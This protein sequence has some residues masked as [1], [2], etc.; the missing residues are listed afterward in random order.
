[1]KFNPLC[2]IVTLTGAYLLFRLR[3]FFILHPFRCLK[4]TCASLKKRQTARS[5]VLALAGT[6]GVGNVFGVAVGISVGGAGSL[7]WM[8]VSSL[9]ASVIKYSEVLLSQASMDKRGSESHG[10]IHNALL[11]LGKFGGVLAVVY[12]SSTLLLSF[13]MG[14]ALQSSTLVS[15]VGQIFDTPPL[16]TSVILSFFVLLAVVGGAAIIERVTEIVIPVTTIIYII[17]CS[18]VIFLCYE[19]VPSALSEVWRSAF[20][21]ES[22]FGGAL[23][24]LLSRSL[25]EG[26][27]RG[28]LSNEAGAGTS[29]MA[30][31]R[32]ASL[33]PA[34]S[35]LMGIVEVFFDTV[36]VCSLTGLAILVSV[37]EPRAHF[38]GMELVFRA[39]CEPLGSF[40]GVILSFCVVAFAY[41]TV[42]CW[43]FYGLES[44]LKL[45]S[46]GRCVF[47]PLYL[48][49]VCVG[50]MIPE[51]V[52]VFA[53]DTLLLI[54]T[55]LTSL[56]LIKSSD[57]I[58]TLSEF[59]GV[60][61]KRYKRGI[62][63]RKS[64]KPDF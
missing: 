18:C 56:V 17:L 28:L 14:A 53:T 24:F 6:L 7:F 34:A 36:L 32:G 57:R 23:G 15:S 12:S 21:C 20:S 1:M 29:S 19:R 31:A 37:P 5:L 39:V 3:F 9:F 45:F 42:I 2:I 26:F 52:L 44:C 64:N 41:S 60:L 33:N 63:R 50:C 61:D 22:A 35:G 43:Y 51:D 40:S 25:S 16:L 47:L 4:K 30:H 58:V 11:A 54:M 49:F 27:A 48:A 62:F 59:G 13:S 8:L 38:G 10:G 46:G 55:A